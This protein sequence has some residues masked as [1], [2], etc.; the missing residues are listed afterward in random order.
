MDTKE[1][2]THIRLK[3]RESESGVA[4]LTVMAL[5]TIFAVVLVGFTYTI[6]MEEGSINLFS[7]SVSV[8]E[9]T[10]AA[11]QGVRAQVARDLDPGKPHYI[12]GRQ[13]P[14]YVSLMDDWAKGY[15]GIIPPGLVY[16]ARSHMD[17]LRPES[18]IQREGIQ[19]YPTP[20]PV[21]VDE[22]PPGDVTGSNR[23]RA[24]T[25]NNNQPVR[26]DR[27]P[28]L[29]GIDDDLDGEV[30][31]SEY[32]DD[33]EDYRVN[34]DGYDL[35]RQDVGGRQ[36]Y[37][38]PGTGYDAD[39]DRRGVFDES[40]KININ[41]AGN[42]FGLSG[43][44]TYNLGASTTE[45]DLPL[46]IYNRVV[47]YQ[48]QAGGISELSENEAE[49]LARN[50]VAFRYGSASQGNSVLTKPGEDNQDDNNNNSPGIL[51]VQDYSE[52][53]RDLTRFDRE[54]FAIIGNE[55]DDDDDG[56]LNEEDERYI[57]PSTDNTSGSPLTEPFSHDRA[58]FYRPGDRID[59]NG[60]GFIDEEREG[61]DDP[62]EF[63]VFKPKGDDRPFATVED[64]GLVPLVNTQKPM[65]KDGQVP[66][67]SLYEILRDSVTIYS[68]SDEISNA[69]SGKSNEIARINPNLST[70]WQANDVWNQSSSND[71]RADFQ[72]S[73]P[74][75]LDEL[76]GLSVDKDGD[77]QQ[78]AEAD[79]TDGI[80]NDGDGFIDEPSDDYDGNLYPSA[81]YDGHSESDPGS[82]SLQ[83]GGDFDQDN[84]I[85]DSN[86]SNPNDFDGLLRILDRDERRN[87]LQAGLVAQGDGLDSDG[88]NIVDDI[89]DANG[90]GVYAFD[91]EYHVA[92]D[93]W[94]DP[95]GD[96]YPGLG[97]DPS[98]DDDSLDGILTKRP[99]IN[100]DLL[101]TSFADDDFDGFP[102]FYDPQVLAAM[103][104][105]ELDNVDNDA[106][107]EVD[108]VGERYI[109]AYDDDED[110]RMD[111][112]PPDFQLAL[113]MV[114]YIDTFMPYPVVD[115]TDVR[116]VVGRSQTD[117]VLAD[118]VTIRTLNLFSSR[119]RALR[120]KPRMFAGANQG[121]TDLQVY[122]E[123]MRL[124]L[125][126]PPEVGFPVRFE[127]VEAIRIN[128]VMAKPVIR[129]EAEDVLEKIE[130]NVSTGEPPEIT[131][132]N[133]RFSVDSGS[134]DDGK[135]NDR[136][137]SNWGIVAD[138]ADGSVLE[139]LDPG[140]NY[141]HNGFE[142]TLNRQLPI[143]NMDTTAPSFIFSVTNTQVPTEDEEFDVGSEAEETATWVF[144]GI[145]AGL[146]DVVLYMDPYDELQ[147]EVQYYFNG[148][149]IIFRSDE[150]VVDTETEP[151][152][153]KRKTDLEADKIEQIRRDTALINNYGTLEEQDLGYRLT[154]YPL[155]P[156][157]YPAKDTQRVVVGSN[158]ILEVEIVANAP[159]TGT[160][161]TSF[162]RLE[163]FNPLVQYVE[164]VNLSTEDIDLSGYQVSTPY[165]MYVLPQ[166]SVI[167][168]SKPLFEED[169]GKDLV[170]TNG[171]PGNGV[172]FEP[173]LQPENNSDSG[174]PLTSDEIDVEDNKL[175]LA[176]HPLVLRNFIRNNYPQNYNNL[177]SGL[178][179]VQPQ[180]V[181]NEQ[182][183]IYQSAMAGNDPS[184]PS[185][186][187]NYQMS[188]IFFK[189]VDKQEDV[190]THNPA[191]KQVTLYDPAGNY[192][193]S[194]RYR[195]TFN[196]AIVD[197]AGNVDADGV[198]EPYDLVA[199]PGYK[200][201]ETFERTDPTY[202]RTE[203]RVDDGEVYG[204]RFVP[205][206]LQLDVK[207]AFIR[208]IA[209]SNNV[210]MQ[211]NSQK[212]IGGYTNGTQGQESD[213]NNGRYRRFSDTSAL[214]I[215]NDTQWN[216]WDFIGDY[217]EYAED[218]QNI[219]QLKTL[220]EQT[221]TM[222]R[223]AGLPRDISPRDKQIYYQMLGGFENFKQT[224]QSGALYP[225]L[226]KYTA[227]TWRLGIRE[228][229]R[230]GYDPDVDDQLTVRVLG[231]QLVHPETGEILDVDL[232]VGEVLVNSSVRYVDPGDTELGQTVNVE[233]N[234]DNP[235]YF[236]Q[237]SVPRPIF[238]K[239]RNGDTAFTIDLRDK[240]SDLTID[241]KGNTEAEPM[242]EITIVIRKSAPDINASNYA[243][244]A[245][246]RLDLAAMG[247]GAITFGDDGDMYAQGFGLNGYIGHMGHDNYFF[248]GIEL[249]GR[250]RSS[251]DDTDEENEKRRYLAGTPGRDNT[252][253]VPA[254]PRRRRSIQGNTRDEFDILDNTPFVKNAPLATLGEISR[255]YTGNKF[256]TVNTP[257]IPQ[258]L[259]DKAVSIQL[260]NNYELG[261]RGRNN[262]DYQIR[263]AQREWL[264]Q[265][266]NQYTNLY[267]KIT[268]SDL[269]IRS[270][271]I[272][273][274][275]APREVL[276]ALPFCPPKT[277][278]KNR[279]EL[280]QLQDRH[281]FNTI[282]ADFILS[283]RKP[284]GH[285][286]HFG[287]HHLDDDGAN[288][289]QINS[290]KQTIVDGIPE[291][292]VRSVGRDPLFFKNFDT[293]KQRFS[294]MNI[295]PKN[296]YD[297]TI[298]WDDVYLASP[299]SYPDDGPY[300]DIGTLL[301]Q[302][303]HLKRRDRL[304][305]RMMSQY[306]RNGDYKLDEPGDLREQINEVI[307]SISDIK[308]ELTTEDM[309]T[310]M[311][312]VSSLM[313]VRSRAFS[314]LAR[315]R[316]FDSDGNIVA[317]RVLETDY[318]R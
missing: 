268:T 277:I 227:F 292:K 267:N 95:N 106:D 182:Q 297:Q 67:P 213:P 161:R 312:R 180:M 302:I 233:L 318:Q 90:D 169:D 221:H 7:D 251:L 136:E 151:R 137:D 172:P 70:N 144:T 305:E 155:A 145:P 190:L 248:K 148:E 160:Y 220:F 77:W 255:L 79:V 53:N 75:Y 10:E 34:E 85:E 218:K 46:F 113:N 164:L 290:F 76:L 45:L 62:S 168:R 204:D 41:F 111:E 259:E 199:L 83:S 269:G 212:G 22:D 82:P 143:A 48:N 165:G 253:Y 254:Y 134:G 123:Q 195:T 157:Q 174:S 153:R 175:L 203:M 125:P 186:Y 179:I 63:S 274:N 270:G 217:Y 177:D 311:N 194:F 17:D 201:F 244:Y 9:S 8:Q 138:P 4:L 66:F 163:L 261:Q 181:T 52:A 16:D 285:D 108:E 207:D 6:R 296:V 119:N 159:E 289:D 291:Y 276:V 133:G 114:D 81:D 173:L 211:F 166:G 91:P 58:E 304:S 162:D 18:V 275:T 225:D 158:G 35:R 229:I 258:R 126:N 184:I 1:R 40:G 156:Q 295:S 191:E 73:P 78:T 280:A 300:I 135:M 178:R 316:V 47:I 286:M 237:Q 43:G 315:G 55:L 11:I 80:D 273:I 231:R 223:E 187:R 103:Y 97:G 260:I 293:I 219:Q 92:E 116:Q 257:L 26:G 142:N 23:F 101:Y 68:Q 147:A 25:R 272:N 98:A 42:N 215:Q 87:D 69:L 19:M 128:E 27:Y 130:Y 146:Y 283:G 208:D 234:A 284:E 239:L 249:F 238:S 206:S 196:N 197:I 84:S 33:D 210:S 298:N 38:P 287:M 115:Q 303:T 241:L 306:D 61:V 167:G 72:Y 59:N 307:Q 247:Q 44:H 24:T 54:P 236:A 112:D 74:V 13:Q 49:T 266:E 149:E 202:F 235:Y 198:A 21:G 242:I 14:R 226:V 86:R 15:A 301:S 205:S 36:V 107:G 3:K 170:E 109:A 309:E 118:P 37:F 243:S 104:T 252:G 28:G 279:Y 57:G 50:I 129:L 245:D 89:G 32:E 120:M 193:D 2:Q 117:P 99:E 317:Q 263:L 294:Q 271:L 192:I 71:N 152:T 51:D 265:W 288:N 240:F 222:A 39:G 224:Y 56:L 230:A 314:I 88:D 214:V 310:I 93:S 5:L 124:L 185:A 94:G 29:K 216:G 232:P 139:E 110:G 150:Y 131:Y 20:I 264:D 102:D 65:L 278:S 154:P 209:T 262:R 188:D 200:G 30:D 60:D 228:L 299:V 100:D 31:N 12:L 132:K 140:Y 176:Y 183:R 256:E 141:R 127:G 250:G 121:M 122:L 171:I 246:S 96:G 189:L 105:P 308:T 281:F 64:L 313:T 282:C